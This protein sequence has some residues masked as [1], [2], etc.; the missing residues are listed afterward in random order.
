MQ[1]FIQLQ[2]DFLSFQKLLATIFFKGNHSSDTRSYG[3]GAK[4]S[5]LKIVCEWF[6]LGEK[7][8]LKSD[9]CQGL[10]EFTWP[11]VFLNGEFLYGCYLSV[12]NKSNAGFLWFCSLYV[13][14]IKGG[15]G[16][17]GGKISILLFISRESKKL[18]R[19]KYNHWNHLF[20][21]L[22]KL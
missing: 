13:N 15:G 8:R 4:I 21:R 18:E 9:H 22:S 5:I 11:W 17:G 16:G 1:V 3:F 7:I 19:Q 2:A 12:Q 14:D 10:S 6:Q 20:I